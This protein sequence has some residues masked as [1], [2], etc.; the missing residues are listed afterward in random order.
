MTHPGR[1]SGPPSGA[2]AAPPGAP[3]TT[4]V[5]RQSTGPRT[6]DSGALAYSQQRPARGPE[7]DDRPTTVYPP[8]RSVLA[9]R[10][11]ERPTDDG[12]V[13]VPESSSMTAAPRASTNRLSIVALILSFL[14]VTAIIGIICGHVA[15]G[16]IRRTKQYGRQL[17]QAALWIGYSYLVAAL[18]CLVVYL[19]IAGQGS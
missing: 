16:Q 10:S 1:P 11:T 13:D 3:P 5:P 7:P 15:S 4:N 2:H 6:A 8:D 12:A 19:A 14:G 18:L 9:E 17:A